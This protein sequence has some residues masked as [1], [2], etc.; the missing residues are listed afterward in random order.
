MANQLIGFE[1]TSNIIDRVGI[2][3][4]IEGSAIAEDVTV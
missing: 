3:N 1:I 2:N 4:L